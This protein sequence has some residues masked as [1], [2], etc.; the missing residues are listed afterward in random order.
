[1]NADE[2]TLA[3]VRRQFDFPGVAITAGHDGPR[4]TI[5]GGGPTLVTVTRHASA[6]GLRLRLTS[7]PAKG[8]QVGLSLYPDDAIELARAIL[9]V[10]GMD[11]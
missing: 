10:A 8:I 1:M 3:P 2:T 7:G 9:S 11:G 5:A 6:I 4:P